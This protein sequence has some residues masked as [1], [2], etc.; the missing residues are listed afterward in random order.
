MLCLNLAQVAGVDTSITENRKDGER[1][2][3]FQ[4]ASCRMRMAHPEGQSL[5]VCAREAGAGDLRWK[6]GGNSISKTAASGQKSR[7][8]VKSLEF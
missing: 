4:L 8:V 5:T 7:A 6:Q 1:A 3:S 2:V